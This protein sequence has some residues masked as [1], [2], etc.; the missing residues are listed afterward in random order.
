MDCVVCVEWGGEGSVC[1][2]CVCVDYVV[3]VECVCGV[4][5]WIV[6]CVL[7]VWRSVCGGTPT[8]QGISTADSGENIG[9][10]YSLRTV[11]HSET[12]GRS[13]KIIEHTSTMCEVGMK[14]ARSLRELT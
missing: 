14:G 1:V 12:H 11:V 4:C 10:L 6:L 2:E 3:C 9:S 7:R 5:V 8:S 13:C